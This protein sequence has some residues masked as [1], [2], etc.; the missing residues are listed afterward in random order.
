M[1]K[2]NYF[3]SKSKNLH[4]LDKLFD[5]Y[6]KK[7]KELE[8]KLKKEQLNIFTE[9]HQNGALK[10]KGQVKDGAYNGKGALYSP[11]G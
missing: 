2:V 7:V 3:F 10:Y 8:E 5:G 11:S 6:K 1:N 9:Y 4:N